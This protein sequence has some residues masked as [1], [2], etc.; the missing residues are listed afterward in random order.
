[1]NPNHLLNADLLMI[2]CTS[3]V[4]LPAFFREAIIICLLLF[5]KRTQRTYNFPVSIP[6]PSQNTLKKVKFER[7]NSLMQ[8][9]GFAYRAQCLYMQRDA[10]SGWGWNQGHLRRL[11]P[12]KLSRRV[13]PGRMMQQN[14]RWW[15]QLRINV[16]EGILYCIVLYCKRAV[17][18]L[19]P[20]V[21]QR[22]VSSV[23]PRQ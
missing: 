10:V 3:I 23:P 15:R 19:F 18:L 17:Q 9:C 8:M 7:K 16:Q 14:N 1:M 6:V 5:T 2:F 12:I 21:T 20:K 22:N 13:Q 4:H 11:S